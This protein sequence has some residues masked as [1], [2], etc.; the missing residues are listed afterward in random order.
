MEKENGDVSFFYDDADTDEP[1]IYERI[2]SLESMVA[3]QG[4]LI[5]ELRAKLEELRDVAGLNR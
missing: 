1:D 5:A 4:R 2:E 3:F